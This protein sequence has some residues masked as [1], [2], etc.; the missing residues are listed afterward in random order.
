[1]ILENTNFYSRFA[2]NIKKTKSFTITGLTMFSRLLLVKYI[3]DIS[4]K[5]IL[6]ITSSEQAALKYKVDFEKIWNVESSLIPYQNHSLYEAIQGNIYD[7]QKQVNVLLEKPDI[8]IAPLK[9]LFEKFPNQ[10]FYEKN[11][12]TLKVG[13]NISQSKL[14]EKLV[15]MGYKRS[16]MVSDMGE[17]S[18]RGDVADIFTLE[19]QP[20]RIEFWGD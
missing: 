9:V 18:I 13:E 16:T 14:L 8:V 15:S 12:L 11:N 5:K 10:T 3:K 19:E 17:F 20:V 6:F 2:N 7:Y 1:M 4:K